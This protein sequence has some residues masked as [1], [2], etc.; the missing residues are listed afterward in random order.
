MDG[1]MGVLG[2]VTI[3]GGMSGLVLIMGLYHKPEVI[4]RIYQIRN[5]RP[6]IREASPVRMREKRNEIEG[7][8]EVSRIEGDACVICMENRKCCVVLPCR[9]LCY[10]I[11]CANKTETGRCPLCR[12]RTKETIRIFN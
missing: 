6:Q 12:Q 10:C 9:H 4:V 3:V 7:K 2:L 5:A 11:G 8:D 1:L